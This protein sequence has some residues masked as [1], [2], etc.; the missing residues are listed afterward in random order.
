M[1]SS[2]IKFAIVLF[3]YITLSSMVEVILITFYLPFICMKKFKKIT[4]LQKK[5]L[6]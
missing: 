1:N 2:E 4:I 6:W 5:K 3:Y